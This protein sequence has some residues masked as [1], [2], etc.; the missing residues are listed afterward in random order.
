[1]SSKHLFDEHPLIVDTTLARILGL[2]EAIVL[3]QVNYW[4]EVNKNKNLNFYDG[5]FW[6]YNSIKDWH[7][8]VFCFWSLVTVK[9]TF[10]SLEENGILVS[11]NY[12]KE[13]RDK[14]KW[15]SIDF[16][17]LEEIINNN[18]GGMNQ[19]IGSICTNG[20][21]QNDPMQEVNLTQP[22][23][24]TS[25]ETNTETNLNTEDDSPTQPSP[26]K[27]TFCQNSNEFR[28]ASY[29]FNYIKKNNSKAKEP[30]IQK[31]CKQFY[32]ILQTDKRDIEDVKK[33]IRWCES[34]SF[35]YKNILSPE[36]LRKH[37]DKLYL[38]MKDKEDN[39]GSIGQ[40]HEPDQNEIYDFTA[41]GG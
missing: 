19:C 41:Y 21:G 10:L 15:Y 8:S 32:Y 5:R 30:N 38:Q 27:K 39:H 40:N 34:D 2:N 29:L 3:Q 17:K 6:T 16:Q 37:Y 23:P 20:L 11:A 31:W 25:T 13:K 12:N 33:V 36:S 1:M 35:W 22:L 4:L 7:D 9:R 28:L 26:P 18:D 24:E 14:T